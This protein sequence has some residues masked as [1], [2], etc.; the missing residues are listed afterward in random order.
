[1]MSGLFLMYAGL[2]VSVSFQSACFKSLLAFCSSMYSTVQPSGMPVMPR[3]VMS[4][5]FGQ[6][7]TP[8]AGA[9]LHCHESFHSVKWTVISV[10]FV[11]P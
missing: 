3:F 10:R 5:A 11:H 6:R 9:S 1:M 7:H 2:V 8:V 4:S